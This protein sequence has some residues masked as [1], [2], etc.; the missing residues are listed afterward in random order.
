MVKEQILGLMEHSMWGNGRMVKRMV[1]EQRLTLIEEN[2][3][4]NGRMV[5]CGTEHFTIK[6]E[7]SK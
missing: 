2:M 4:E 5:N 3:W 7:S 6:T 1:M